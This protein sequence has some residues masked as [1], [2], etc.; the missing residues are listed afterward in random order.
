MLYDAPGGTVTLTGFDVVPEPGS[1]S[2][3]A[4]GASALALWD[5]CESSVRF[6]FGDALGDPVADDI[7]NALYEN[8]SQGMSRTEIRD[9][10][11]RHKTADQ[12]DRALA[13]LLQYGHARS[14]RQETDGRPVARWYSVTATK[15]TEAIK[16]SAE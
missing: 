8:G 16:A 5:Y 7:R 4:L 10:F 11:R 9:F 15:A 1:F 3:V 12:I 13:I 14:E 6:I 2:L